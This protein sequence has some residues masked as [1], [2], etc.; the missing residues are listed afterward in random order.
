[1]YCRGQLP[2]VEQVDLYLGYLAAW[3]FTQNKA[4][5]C[6]DGELDFVLFTESVGDVHHKACVSL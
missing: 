4:H 5:L 2:T 3:T 6:V 1:M